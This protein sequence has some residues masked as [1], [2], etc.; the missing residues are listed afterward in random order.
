M[1]LVQQLAKA[2]KQHA[3]EVGAGNSVDTTSKWVQSMSCCCSQLQAVAENAAKKI[4]AKDKQ[5]EAAIAAKAQVISV[6]SKALVRLSCC[7]TAKQG[8]HR[9]G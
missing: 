5:L 7:L 4:A 3:L 8:Q 1:Q 6:F 2:K 9:V